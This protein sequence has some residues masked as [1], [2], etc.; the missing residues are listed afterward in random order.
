MFVLIYGDDGTG[1]SVQAMKIAEMKDNPLHVSMA[2]KNRD[3][4]KDGVVTSEEILVFG[5][6]MSINPYETIDNFH[7][8]VDRI[9]KENVVDMV[10]ID[11]ISLL[12]TWAQ[13]C[14]L[15]WWNRSYSSK[16]TKIGENNALAWE[17][18]NKITYGYIERLTT[19]AALNNVV[20]VAI[21][22]LRDVRILE[23]G[24]DGKSHSVATGQTTVN[25]KDNVKKLSDIR[26]RLEKDGKHGKGYYA[27]FEKYTDKQHSPIEKDVIK[28]ERDGILQELILR[29]VM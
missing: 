3:L 6:D 19:W 10:V 20:V 9:I 18:V 29:G 28:V 21:T 15:E 7:K 4:Y 5:N 22:S 12:R 17:H 27:T 25:A 24:D 8:I 23:K 14:T 1:K 11:E 26:V 16:I 13:A 2:V